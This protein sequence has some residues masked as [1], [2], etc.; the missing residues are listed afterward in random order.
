MR[1]A[2]SELAEARNSLASAPPPFIAPPDPHGQQQRDREGRKMEHVRRE[3][4]TRLAL[5]QRREQADDFWKFGVLARRRRGP[6]AVPRRDRLDE[7]VGSDE[8]V[9]AAVEEQHGPDSQKVERLKRGSWRR[10]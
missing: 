6:F 3:N 5:G 10:W 4:R 1:E 7:V 8:R 9:H 2:K